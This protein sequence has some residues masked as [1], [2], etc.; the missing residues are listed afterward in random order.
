[1]R[2]EEE[3]ESIYPDLPQYLYCTSRGPKYDLMMILMHSTDLNP[4]SV[5]SSRVLH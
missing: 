1:M 4:I 5:L 2:N 3:L